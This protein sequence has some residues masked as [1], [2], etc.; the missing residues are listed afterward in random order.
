[1]LFRSLHTAQN[2]GPFIQVGQTTGLAGYVANTGSM[3]AS[4]ITPQQ[5]PADS[6]TGTWL[7]FNITNPNT[8][9]NYGTYDVTEC[10]TYTTGQPL[11]N[12]GHLAMGMATLLHT[13]SLS[14]A[15]ASVYTIEPVYFNVS[16]HGYPTQFVTGI[17]PVYYCSPNMGNSG[18]T[19]NVN[20]DTYTFFN[21]SI[22]GL[23]MKTS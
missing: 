5:N 14:A 13:N 19:V 12:N 23:L 3:T 18:D 11:V 2:I 21:A 15:G 22:T 10:S 7:V 16:K 1:M 9:I 8:G 4:R 20:G 6:N 17:V